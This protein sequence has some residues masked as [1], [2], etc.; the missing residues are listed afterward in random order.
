MAEKSVRSIPFMKIPSQERNL[1][2]QRL[3]TEL[4]H[5]K[6]IRRRESP[7]YNAKAMQWRISRLEVRFLQ[8]APIV[9][10]GTLAQWLVHRSV[11]PAIAVQ[12]RGVPPI[13][14]QDSLVIPLRLGRRGRPFESGIPD[15]LGAQFNGRIRV[16]KTPDVGSIPSAPANFGLL[17][18]RQ[19][20]GL[21][22][23]IGVFNSPAT[24]HTLGLWSNGLGYF[25]VTEVVRVRLPLDPPCST[26]IQVL[27]H[28][29]NVIKG[30]RV[31]C[32]APYRPLAQPVRAFA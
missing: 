32:T 8:W 7:D 29:A 12:L 19:N 13:G 21:L 17:V 6:K 30:V 2:V 23:R 16:S 24:R 1:R 27:L 14:N 15:H 26:R 4:L 25:P 3:Y 9:Y 5:L 28:V 11:E 22:I 10:M 20:S 31:S 18:H